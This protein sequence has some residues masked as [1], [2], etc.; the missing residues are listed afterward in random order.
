MMHLFLIAVFWIATALILYTYAGFPVLLALRAV[1][2]PKLVKRGFD[3]PK[4]SMIIAAHNEED[5]IVKKL[6]NAL[7]LNY[8]NTQFEVI[9]ASDGSDDATN[10]L[11]AQYVSPEV[12]LLRLPRLGKNRSVN[13]A[14]AAASGDI[15][16]F[17][18]ADSMLTPD[19]LRHLVA[20]FADP[21]VGGVAGDY[22]Y[23][24]DV[25]G[26]HA[27]RTYWGVD[28]ILKQQQS[29]GG[30]ITSAS[31]QLY[32]L[33][34]EIFKEVPM[35]VS[36]D[37][38]TSIQVPAAHKRLVFEPLAVAYGPVAGNILSEF[39]RKVRII[40][41]SMSSMMNMSVLLNP[42]RYGFYAL[43]IMSHKVLRWMMFVPLIIL[44]FVSP[45]LW[46]QGFIYQLATVSQFGFYSAAIIAYLGRNTR[47][48]RIKPL[49]LPLFFVMVNLAALIAFLNFVRGK[50][51]H[52]W[53]AQRAESEQLKEMVLSDTAKVAIPEN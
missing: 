52:V 40:T 37:I 27:E 35:T 24:T 48:A 22:R 36:D 4:V 20:P 25:E 16:V 21:Q 3:T 8:P 47:L 38:F 26:G 9:V 2:K 17:T 10:D 15:L 14:V 32:A 30:S 43:Q 18:D 28:R 46:N 41:R 44:F 49:S 11:V 31:G 1:L 33:R 51:Y 5:V 6:E 39:Q 23:V 12:Q 53:T 29:Y 7:S 45:L 34:R 50:T 42:R 19:S 13:A